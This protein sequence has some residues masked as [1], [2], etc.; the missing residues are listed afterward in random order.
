MRKIEITKVAESALKSLTPPEQK[1]ALSLLQKAARSISE[2]TI[3]TKINALK[4]TEPNFFV[5]KLNPKLRIIVELLE[6]RINVVDI[7]NHD[8]FARYFKKG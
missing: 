6:D 2:P 5:I 8:L 4:I 3:K 1:K 7:I